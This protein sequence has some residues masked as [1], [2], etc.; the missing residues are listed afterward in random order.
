[1]VDAR[2]AARAA[3]RDAAR[4]Y[5]KAP[6][7]ADAEAL[8]LAA[9]HESL[10]GLGRGTSGALV[11]LLEGTLVRCARVTIRVRV[12]VPAIRVPWVGG[13]GNG[14]VVTARHSEIVDPYR[15]GLNGTGPGGGALCA[16]A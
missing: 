16:A 8:A 3:A 4:A 15:S 5:V 1:V 14:F 10:N 9:A 12:T 11:D 6:T 13:W 2:L 7:D